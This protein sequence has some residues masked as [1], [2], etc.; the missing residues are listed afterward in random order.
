MAMTHKARVHKF[1]LLIDLAR[2]RFCLT[3]SL[4]TTWSD[5]VTHDNMVWSCLSW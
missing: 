2:Y 1:F 4:R 5:P 3:C